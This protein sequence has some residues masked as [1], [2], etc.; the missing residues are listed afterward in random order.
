MEKYNSNTHKRVTEYKNGEKLC[1][2]EFDSTG[3]ELLYIYF[4]DNTEEK[5]ISRYDTSGFPL[6][7]E[8]YNND[9]L[10]SVIKYDYEFDTN[11]RPLKIITE[12][13]S[14]KSAR[15]FSYSEIND[16]LITTSYESEIDFEQGNWQSENIPMEKIY[17]TELSIMRF[18]EVVV[19]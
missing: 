13:D 3:N 1:Y 6:V 19:S 11:H 2:R 16:T 14:V 12:K 10:I 8:K 15:I 17:Y 9:S 5:T 7:K 4:N 18:M